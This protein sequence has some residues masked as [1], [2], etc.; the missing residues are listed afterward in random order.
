MKNKRNIIQLVT[1]ILYNCNL[2]GFI[3]S[4]I[5]TGDIKKICVPGLNCYSCPGAIA[6]CPLGSFQSA[7]LNSKYNGIPFYVLGFL[8]L[9]GII[10]ARIICGFLCPFGLLQELLYKI[11]TK[12]IRK[13]NLTKKLSYLKYIILFIFVI[14]IP[15]IFLK[16]GFCKYICPITVFLKPASYFSYLRVKCDHEKC[17]QCKKCVND[18]P[19]N[20]DILD[21]SRKRK[22]G[23]ECILCCNCI[24]E[25]PK[26]AIEL[27]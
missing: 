8:I 24:N 15:I 1:A 5:Y 17:I 26:N 18:C 6:S 21:D 4:E 23:T 2:P 16:P 25:C 19:M 11:K 7:L 10:L 12:K 9:F 20:V 27:K 22:N 3:K 13:N 14:I